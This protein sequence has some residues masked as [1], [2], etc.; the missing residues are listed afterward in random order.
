MPE[1][2]K[3]ENGRFSTK[4]EKGG[5]DRVR[6]T[7]YEPIRLQ[8]SRYEPAISQPDCRK[9]GPYQ[10]S[11]DTEIYSVSLRVKSKTYPT[12]CAEK[13]TSIIPPGCEKDTKVRLRFLHNIMALFSS[14]DDPILITL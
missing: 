7:G 3:P 2:R 1:Q 11:Y 10:L 12:F 6:R 8:E 9:A 13:L 4:V 14:L 5:R